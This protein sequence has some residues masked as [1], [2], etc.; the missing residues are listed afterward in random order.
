MALTV[1]GV[2]LVVRRRGEEDL[3]ERPT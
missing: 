3:K 2:A 1:V